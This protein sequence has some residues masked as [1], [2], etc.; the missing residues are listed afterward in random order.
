M[1]RDTALIHNSP[2]KK[3]KITIRWHKNNLLGLYLAILLKSCQDVCQQSLWWNEPVCSRGGVQSSLVNKVCQQITLEWMV[4]LKAHKSSHVRAPAP[5]LEVGKGLIFLI[6][7]REWIWMMLNATKMLSVT[8]RPH[9]LQN[10]LREL[11][12]FL[13][14]YTAQGR[15]HT[16]TH[17]FQLSVSCSAGSC[18]RTHLRRLL[19]TQS[20]HT[21][22][23]LPES[24]GLVCRHASAGQ[25][26]HCDFDVERYGQWTESSEC[27]VLDEPVMFWRKQIIQLNKTQAA[28]SLS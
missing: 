2:K 23:T 3:K 25:K 5:F 27:V 1:T 10:K 16:Q 6:G 21:P 22:H 19:Y 18:V 17:T 12:A 28:L 11:R 7:I 14:C 26:S 13:S 4:A 9:R 24:Q 15:R 20:W 8:E